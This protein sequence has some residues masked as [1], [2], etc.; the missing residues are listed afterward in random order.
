VS[1]AIEAFGTHRIV[2]GTSTALPTEQLAQHPITP[3]LLAQP[4]SENEWYAEL[5]D[6][7]T[8]LGEGEVAVSDVFGRNAA[9]LYKLLEKE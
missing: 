8:R 9:G 7:L 1:P 3:V 5:R 2:F 4:V 6:T